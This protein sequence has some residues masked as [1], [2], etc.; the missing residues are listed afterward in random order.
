M[1]DLFKVHYESPVGWL[2]ISADHIGV[3]KLEFGKI[4]QARGGSAVLEN[5]LTDLD[6]YFEGRLFKFDC[7]LSLK[8]SSFQK[9]VWQA[10]QKIPY[11]A[12]PSYSDIAAEIGRPSAVRAVG[13]ANNKN[14]MPIIIPCHRVIGRDGSL[15]GY[16]AGLDVKR[17][18]LDLELQNDGR[19][20]SRPHLRLTSSMHALSE[21]SL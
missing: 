21:F 7:P 8:G 2:T 19:R 5:I 10:L 13:L 9:D 16:V 12:V 14:P 20:K 17:Y 3:T 4:E 18:L 6:L 11:G 15:T 1:F